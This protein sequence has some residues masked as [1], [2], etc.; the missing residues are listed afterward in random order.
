MAEAAVA[1]APV[2]APVKKGKKG[3]LFIIIGAV[4]LLGAAGGGAWFFMRDAG[5]K[6]ADAKHAAKQEAAA[7]KKGPA[8]YIALDPP[9]VVNF[10]AQS[11]V[12]FLQVTLQIMT[13]DAA[14]QTL[15]KENDPIVRNDLISLLGNLEYDS[16]ST[17]EG[18]E[19]LRQK[20][21][22]T[23]RK[24][25]TDEGGKGNLVEAVY[26]TSFVMQ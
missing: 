1:E 9:F 14:T 23:V 7:V 6:K 19:A 26:F 11:M 22:A 25:V 18:K 12:R 21:L 10:K 16:I 17:T 20:A 13:R 2:A 8:L 5:D 3:M 15:I 4:V 24:I